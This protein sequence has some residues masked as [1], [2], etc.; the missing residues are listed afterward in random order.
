[1]KNQK[2]RWFGQN[3]AKLDETSNKEKE[4]AVAELRE[5]L[6]DNLRGRTR[7]GAHSEGVLG[8]DP[9]DYYIEK[10]WRKLFYGIWEWKEG[11]TL[12]GQ[13]KRTASS[14]L[15]K[16]VKKYRN[17]TK[18][19]SINPDD[20]A[21]QTGAEAGKPQGWGVDMWLRADLD[22]ERMGDKPMCVMSEDGRMLTEEE[23]ALENTYELILEVVKGKPEQVQYVLEVKKGGHYDDIAEAMDI[24]VEEVL[25][26]ERRVLRKLIA[27]RMKQQER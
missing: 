24:E 16:Q 7:Y 1:M 9:V 23:A 27:Y 14:L 20:E 3:Q 5:Y 25:L 18:V 15:Q 19:T 4:L 17:A 26:I 8:C 21:A 12:A 22:M 2:G 6:I 13:L 10:A 11:R